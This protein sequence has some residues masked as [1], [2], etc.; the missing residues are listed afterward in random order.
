[1]KSVEELMAINLEDYS[2]EEI[3]KAL[4]K[5]KQKYPAAYR[6]FFAV[7]L[8]KDCDSL[9]NQTASGQCTPTG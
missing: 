5:C 9:C 1:M 8:E 2:K 7:E 3:I 6:N 4:N